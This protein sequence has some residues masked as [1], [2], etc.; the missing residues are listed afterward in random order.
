MTRDIKNILLYSII[1]LIYGVL[2]TPLIV[3]TSLFFPYITGKA[4]AFRI[5]V[6][7]ATLLYIVLV[8]FDRT[9]LP[10]K[11]TILTAI[12]A[13]TVVLGI[14]TFTAEDPSRSFW[15]NFER[16]EGYVTILHLFFFFVVTTSVFQTKRV[17]YAL[18]N[19]TLGIS[20]VLGLCAFAD[21]DTARNNAF[22][23]D[24]F[25]GIKYSSLLSLVIQLKLSVLQDHWVTQVILVCT[26]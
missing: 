14:S 24:I 11:G 21:Y 19:T 5:L 23:V 16:M 12:V 7:L 15:S 3:S 18:F 9:F 22:L 26:H 4:F 17:W 2:L 20:V 25:K 10:K 8:A 1:A 6:E 13:F